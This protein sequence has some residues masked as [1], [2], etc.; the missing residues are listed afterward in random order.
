[1][2]GSAIE[3]APVTIDQT[4]REALPYSAARRDFR[5]GDLLCFRGRGFVS[6]AIRVLT[7]SPYS[8]AGLVYRLKDRVFALEAVGVGVRLI[9]MS[10]LVKRYHGGI[11][12][13]AVQEVT[14]GQRELAI[15]FA[16]SQLGK[17]YDHWGVIRFLWFL[18]TGRR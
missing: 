2:Q 17:L 15:D 8:H 13:F 11:D 16:F 1:M 3:S 18:L 7:R 4:G 5:G 9:L 6:W 12:Y 14:D 10:E